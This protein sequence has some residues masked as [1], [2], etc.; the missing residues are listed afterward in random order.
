MI[1]KLLKNRRAQQTAEYALLITLVVGAVIAMQTYAQRALQGR[2]RAAS[3][4]MKN[5]TSGLGSSDLQYEPYYLK[6]DYT[7]ARES[8]DE[9]F[10][11]NSTF[12]KGSI[13]NTTRDE[14][15]FEQKTYD[16]SDKTD[17]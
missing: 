15:G 6:K 1:R 9:E 12:G 16:T 4:Y 8:E 5:E 3:V 17:W 2:I 10:L 14:E 7:I 13:S 11:R